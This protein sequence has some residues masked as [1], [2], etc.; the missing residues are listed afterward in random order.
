MIVQPEPNQPAF[1]TSLLD[2]I[3]ADEFQ[4][5]DFSQKI[6]LS[7]IEDYNFYSY[8]AAALGYF[9]LLV[10]AL[11]RSQK[12]PVN[13]YLVLALSASLA[14][15]GYTAFALKTPAIYISEA[16]PLETLYYAGWFAFL[17]ILI[18]HQ[19][20]NYNYALLSHYRRIY[21]L[22]LLV[23]AALLLETGTEFRYFVQHLIAFDPRFLFHVGFAITGLVLIEQLYRNSNREQRWSVKFLCLGLGTLF[24]VDFVLYSHSLLYE[25]L[26]FTIW[27]S[28]GFIHLLSAPLLAISI[29]RIPNDTL[30]TEISVS[31]Q[32][33]FH[34]AILFGTGLYL[35]LMSAAGITS[36]IM[37]A[38]GG[39]LRKLFLSQWPFCC[40]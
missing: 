3:Q 27:D 29:R 25:K 2:S 16:L 4:A 22:P 36:G 12:N 18:I 8:S 35:L 9:L 20:F 17:I 30:A 23:I 34:T 15:S 10:M 1:T 5:A 7:I 28:R 39:K 40:C 24:L 37:V 33:V 13:I 11:L 6:W 21:V 26:D 31:R 14:W 32:V 38:V 19:Q